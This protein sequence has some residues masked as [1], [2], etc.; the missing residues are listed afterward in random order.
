V[1]E[2]PARLGEACG[3][4][5]M[6]RRGAAVDLSHRTRLEGPQFPVH[7]GEAASWCAGLPPLRVRRHLNP[8]RPR[9]RTAGTIAF[10]P[11]SP[12]QGESP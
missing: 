2:S 5:A 8:Q 1:D 3:R 12:D 7:R 6:L 11:Q 4:S 9:P 10:P